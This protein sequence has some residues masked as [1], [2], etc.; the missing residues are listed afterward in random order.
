M[1]PAG[2]DSFDGQSAVTGVTGGFAICPT[3]ATRLDYPGKVPILGP[4]DALPRRPHRVLIAGTSGSGKTTL[5]G[6][7]SQVLGLPH[8]EID[9]LFHGPGWVGRPEFVDDVRRFSAEP[10]WVTEWQY[11]QVRD[12]LADRS[13]LMIWLD[14][15]RPVVMRQVIRRTLRRRLGRQPLWNGNLEPPLHTMFTDPEHILRWAWS[16]HPLIG[17]RVAKVHERRPELTIVRLRDRSAVT[18][19]AGS[20]LV[21]AA[22]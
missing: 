5:A 8:T 3:T 7:V 17:P 19:W 4:D 15:P 1:L 6:R 18:R 14:L 20:A 21:D 11:G 10:D 9:G 22:S 13:D 12:L 2:P 16:N